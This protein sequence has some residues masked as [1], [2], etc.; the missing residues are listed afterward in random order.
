MK[1]VIVESPTKAIT[2]GKFLGKEYKVESSYG[3]VRDLPKSKIG[4]DVLHNFE[5][6]YL[7]PIKAKKKVNEL[8]K[9]V[10]KAEEIILATDEDR[11]GEAISW[12]LVQAL[13][14]ENIK[15]Q[16]SNRKKKTAKSKTEKISE[17]S[18]LP[19]RLHETS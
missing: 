8:K 10:P 13:N 19:K 9:L 15:S 4:I 1:L 7:I 14:L 6:S 17:P 11:E 3:H 16:V 12:H 18:S 5:P 2:I